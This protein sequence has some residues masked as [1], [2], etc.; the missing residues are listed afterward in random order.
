MAL[1]PYVSIRWA[2][3][4]EIEIPPHKIR[5]GMVLPMEVTEQ[6][7]LSAIFRK[8]T[9]SQRC[10]NEARAIF[11]KYAMGR[12]AIQEFAEESPARGGDRHNGEEDAEEYAT[13]RCLW[14]PDIEED[15]GCDS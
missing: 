6:A 1:G 10:L 13:G 12:G 9:E 2:A 4:T 15:N 3:C 5:K 11:E 7:V 14:N 8:I